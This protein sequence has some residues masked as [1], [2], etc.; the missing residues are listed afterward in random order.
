ME[1]IC[2]KIVSYSRLIS[3]SPDLETCSQN[4]VKTMA[5]SEADEH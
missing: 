3:M 2:L 1:H 5:D 4:K